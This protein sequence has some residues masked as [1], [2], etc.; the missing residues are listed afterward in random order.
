MFRMAPA[1]GTGQSYAAPRV[2]GDKRRSFD[3]N[4]AQIYH[5][6]TEVLDAAASFNS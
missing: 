5:N 1:I 3:R 6:A 4:A 2:L